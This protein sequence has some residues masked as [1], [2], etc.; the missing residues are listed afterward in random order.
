MIIALIS[1]YLDIKSQSGIWRK[2]IKTN[3]Q[4]KSINGSSKQ[5]HIPC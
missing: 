5:L 4:P 2:I 1:E 3:N